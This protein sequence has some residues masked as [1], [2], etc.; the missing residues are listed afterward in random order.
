MLDHD[1]LASHDEP[2]AS[3]ITA[4]PGLLDTGAVHASCCA[5]AEAT[6]V[7]DTV[8]DLNHEAATACAPTAVTEVLWL[9]PGTELR[10]AYLLT[11]RG[12]TRTYAPRIKK[13]TKGT[14]TPR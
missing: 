11:A 9:I 8:A 3:A 14:D 10:P 5:L 1:V 4:S 7:H 6:R 12:N 2:H 13:R